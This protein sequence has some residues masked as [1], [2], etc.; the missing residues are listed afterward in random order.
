MFSGIYLK[1]SKPRLTTSHWRIY[2]R[3]LA[4][5]PD[6]VHSSPIEWGLGFEKL[7]QFPQRIIHRRNSATKLI[8]R[9]ERDSNS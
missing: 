1:R 6:L 2:L 7:T 9:R 8:W 5:A 3:L 4:S